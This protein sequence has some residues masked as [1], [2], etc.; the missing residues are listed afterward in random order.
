LTAESLRT[1]GEGHAAGLIGVVI[2]TF[3]AGDAV[4]RALDAL[5][6]AAR[7][8]EATELDVV[9]VDN[10]SGD[11]TAERIRRHAP[12][13]RVVESPRNVGFAAGC[14]IGVAQ[15][16]SADVIVLLNPDVEVRADFLA[17]LSALD[18][19]AR[20]AARGPA[21]FDEH[22]R[23]EQSA[24]G[25]PRARTGVLGRSS[26]L[27]RVCPGSRLLRDD[28]RADPDAGARVVDWVSGAC[29]IAPAAR[30]REIGPLDEDYFMYWED[31]DWCLRA[32]RLGY[33]ILYD[34]SLVVT[35]RQGTSSA[36]RPV[37]T[38]IAF[39]RSAF[40]YWRLNIARDPISLAIGAVALT[41]RC[42]A[43]LT[44]YAA[45]RASLAIG[46]RRAG[47]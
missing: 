25:F 15:M 21:V 47:A 37:A 23:V 16:H 31:A 13:A 14:N 17:C 43:R 41:V 33:Q 18:W 20:V 30:L 35:H 1:G 26:L 36:E 46:G 8:L 11:G 22:G 39:H 9:I 42:A 32:K 19:P 10:A 38:T 3:R 12:S 27:A 7:E 40:R 29:L 24:R 5:D 4:M 2:V 34:P 44:A 45:R 28:L 6:T